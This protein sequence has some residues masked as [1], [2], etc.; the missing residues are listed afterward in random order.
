M[1]AVWIPH[2]RLN[3]LL[4]SNIPPS[5]SERVAISKEL[6]L[7]HS[8]LA[9][10]DS[11]S[12]ELQHLSDCL[13]IVASPIRR[14]NRDILHHIFLWYI[15]RGPET[16]ASF[17]C[18]PAPWTIAVVCRSWREA[19]VSTSAL[20]SFV[21]LPMTAPQWQFDERTSTQMARAKVGPLH[22]KIA[23]DMDFMCLGELTSLT[24]IGVALSDEDVVSI[25][26]HIP[27][28]QQLSVY[29]LPWPGPSSRPYRFIA[30]ITYRPNQPEHRCLAPLLTDVAIPLTADTVNFVNSRSHDYDCESA[31][32]VEKLRR[33]DLKAPF[34][35]GAYNLVDKMLDSVER[36]V[37]IYGGPF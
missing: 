13:R 19:A 16:F 8:R 15:R 31:D 20:W 21:Q 14:V 29:N 28:V 5:D 33:V 27:Q 35:P 17:I 24:I 22:F 23:P 11:S 37:K 6:S 10:L 1:K 7:C 12:D 34:P 26:S 4:R 18:R 3:D 25:I 30:N 32:F 36:G 9:Q 2:E